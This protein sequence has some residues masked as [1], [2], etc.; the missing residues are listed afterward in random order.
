M[1]TPEIQRKKLRNT[2]NDPPKIL[3]MEDFVKYKENDMFLYVKDIKHTLKHY[4]L[5]LKIKGKKKPMLEDMLNDIFSQLTSLSS[6]DGNIKRITRIQAL[7]KAR[8]IRRDISLYGIGVFDHSICNNK[9]DFY[10][11]E[12]VDEILKEY[13]FS[14]KDIDGF[15]YGFDIRSFQKLLATQS[16]NPYTRAEIPEYTINSF[17]NR[18]KY[19][20]KY[21]I[22]IDDFAREKITPEQKFKNKVVEIFQKIDELDTIAGGTDVNWFLNM[23]F[24]DLKNYYKLLEDI[25]NYRANLT[26]D[27]KLKI[28]PHND[29]FT[30]S[31]NYILNLTPS[32]E[33]KLRIYILNEI[34]KMV[35]SAED[36]SQRTTGAYYVLT[37]FAEMI[38]ACAQ[39][40]PWLVQL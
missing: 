3:T 2:P 26:Q 38:P 36:V 21:N 5:G 19:M 35:S 24:K 29:M 14:Y 6:E 33:K 20:L 16:T 40:L 34:D 32:N 4:G 18:V 17:N 8:K 9:D 1:E 39:S 7:F 37:A 12:P 28:V 15:V 22:I 23:D 10:T 31:M 25:W 30:T 11:F 13:F 27:A